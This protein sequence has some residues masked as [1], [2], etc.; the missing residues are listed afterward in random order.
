MVSVKLQK[1]ENRKQFLE[2]FPTLADEV[3]AELRK[4]NMPEDAYEWTKKVSWV[5]VSRGRH[6]SL[7]H[8]LVYKKKKSLKLISS[9][10]MLYYNVPGG[11]YRHFI[12]IIFFILFY[13]T[14]LLF[15]ASWT[16]VF[17]LSTLLESWRVIL[18]LRMISS[19]LPSWVGLLSL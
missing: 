8:H 12:F 9:T 1:E 6:S 10:Q 5:M 2:V 18:L 4:Y 3:L 14:H 13:S 17:L 11:M 19:R 15:Q 7:V 16:V